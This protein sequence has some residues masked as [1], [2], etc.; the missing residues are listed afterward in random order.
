MNGPDFIGIGVQRGGTSWLYQC[1]KEHPDIF[2]PGKELHFFDQQYTKGIDWYA[3]LFDSQNTSLVKGEMTPDYIFRQEALMR[4][5]EHYPH[6][7]LILILREP[8][9]RANSAV[10]LLKS[11]GRYQNASFKDIVEKE[12]W[13]IEQSLY[14]KQL[15]QLFALFPREQVKIYLFEDIA[16]RPLWLLKDIFEFIGVDSAFRPQSFEEK[17]NISATA[18]FIK[19]V[20]LEKL[21]TRLQGNSA[22][23]TVLKLKKL[24]V[25]KKLKTKLFESSGEPQA[26]VIS[27]SEKLREAIQADILKTEKLLGVSLKDWY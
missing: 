9:E 27:C 3:S 25:M 5:K 20:N 1:F 4:I 15:C 24:K 11:R 6:T 8:L 22:G 2:M 23:R 19:I 21:Q 13:I 26:S 17:F 16:N 7:K 10:G 14:Y 18:R 12:K